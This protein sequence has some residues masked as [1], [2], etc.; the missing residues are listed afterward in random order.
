M[1]TEFNCV[2][3][4]P[5]ALTAP[6]DFS[7]AFFFGLYGP[8]NVRSLT[9]IESYTPQSLYGTKSLPTV[10]SN[11]GSTGIT[12]VTPAERL[13]SGDHGATPTVFQVGCVRAWG[14]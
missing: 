12:A 13:V 1:W 8:E 14:S 6:L 10:Q 2:G 5:T 7:W 9:Q 3:F 11:R 4:Q